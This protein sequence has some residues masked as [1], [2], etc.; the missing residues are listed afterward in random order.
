[1]TD[2]RNTSQAVICLHDIARYVE[3]HIGKGAL[4]DDIRS[5]ADRLSDL[6]KP[7]KSSIP[8]A[9]SVRAKQ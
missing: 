4:S 9:A 6:N 1:M 3:H 8:T 7:M 2:I 5:A